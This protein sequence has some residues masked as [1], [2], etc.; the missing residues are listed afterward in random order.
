MIDFF[1]KHRKMIIGVMVFFFLI[2]MLLP[3]MLLFVR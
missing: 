3:S 2:S 1:K